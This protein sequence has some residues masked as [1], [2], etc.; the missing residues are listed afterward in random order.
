MLDAIGEGL[1]DVS[2]LTDKTTCKS[3]DF[4]K[5]LHD[6]AEP[7]AK[8][9][10]TSSGGGGLWDDMVS[11]VK[12]AAGALNDG[13]HAVGHAADGLAQD[14]ISATT[15]AVR[16]VAGDGAATV[17]H[18]VAEGALNTTKQAAEFTY[19]VGEG[20][21]SAAGDMVTGTVDMAKN[22]VKF[23]TNSAYR[24]QVVNSAEH[25]AS[26][27][28]LG[29]AKAIGS[30]VVH[31]GENWLRG[32]G[33]A[34]QEGNLGEYLGKGTGSA[35]VNIGSFFVPGA[36][37]A[38][39]AN[40]LAHGSE[41]VG[42]VGDLAKSGEALG[43]ASKLEKGGEALGDAGKL[44]RGGEA[45][46]GAADAARAGRQVE[47]FDTLAD[48]NRA[49]NHAKPDTDYHYG[50]YTW[51]TDA[52][53][54]VSSVEGCVTLDK[55]GRVPT[56][57]VDTTSIGKSKDSQPGDV[58]FHLVGDQFNGPVNR[59]NV[60]PGNGV[61]QGELKSL[62]LSGYKRWENE[63]SGLARDPN[64]T[65]EIRVEASYKASNTTTRPDAFNASYRVNG[66][67][68]VTSVFRNR[69]GG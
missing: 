18:G 3:G 60:V 30:G 63:V 22:G 8:R 16:D 57:G 19:G 43:D 37:A 48:F 33:Q 47:N 27:V 65:V 1:E 58:G 6:D 36:D 44:D 23:A 29:T 9:Q 12:S 11:G 61:T 41:A 15:K 17:F 69:A 55:N 49:A 46:K 59:L 31:A 28:A 66:G 24:G 26:A 53:G 4:A 39:G 42:A 68:W 2:K 10:K 38:E 64:N 32:A 56:D 20:A 7:A 50:N 34:A 13:V 5:A 62:N 51:S 45:D 14:G 35:A 54:R 52:E 21:A 67:D 25:L 40:V